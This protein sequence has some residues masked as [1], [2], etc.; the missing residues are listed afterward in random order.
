[1]STTLY[2]HY[3]SSD[4]QLAIKTESLSTTIGTSSLYD[5]AYPGTANGPASINAGGADWVPTCWLSP[6]IA[7]GGGATISGSITANLWMK[8]SNTSA[9]VGAK[10]LIQRCD[11]SGNVISTI[12]SSA[13][14]TEVGTSLSAQN[15]SISP[16]STILVPGNRILVTVFGVD[17]GGT[18][19]TGYTMAFQYD[20]PAGSGNSY[21]AFAESLTFGAWTAAPT[22][23][24]RRSSAWTAGAVKVR[25]SSAWVAPTAVKVRRSGAWTTVT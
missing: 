25:R 23:K 10:V 19:K 20:G 4:V 22:L 17:A 6:T 13:K 11:S 5:S 12:A 15:W 2:A 18:M 3:A 7:D 14:G 21:V 1:M 24:V 8:E 16:T 9:N